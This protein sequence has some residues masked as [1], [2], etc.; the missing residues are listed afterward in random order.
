MA[1]IMRKMQRHA[2]SCVETDD[3]RK[4]LEEASGWNLTEFF[5][6][7]VFGTGYPTVEVRAHTPHLIQ[8]RN[9]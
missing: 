2:E 8:A 1:L 5:D 7:W 9:T 6:Q 4:I 3:F